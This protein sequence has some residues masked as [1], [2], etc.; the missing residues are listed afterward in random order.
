M[1]LYAQTSSQ[2]PHPIQRSGSTYEVKPYSFKDLT[3]LSWDFSLN[4]EGPFS[5]IFC[6]RLRGAFTR[7]VVFSISAINCLFLQFGRHTG[8]A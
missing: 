3:T 8:H 5:V 2:R 1:A 7:N 4:V 6:E